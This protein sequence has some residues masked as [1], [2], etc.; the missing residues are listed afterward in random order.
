MNHRTQ[1]LKVLSAGVLSLILTMGVARFAYTPMLPI[2]QEQAGLGVS[3]GVWLAATNYLGYLAGALV[4]SMI[5]DLVLKD[6]LYRI[7]LL[8]AVLTT[9]GMGLTDNVWLWSLLRFLAG[10]STAAGMLLGSGLIMNWLIRHNHRAELGVTF[11]GVGLGMVLCAVA[12]ELMSTFLSWNDQWL[13]LTL[14]G[15]LIMILAWRWLPPP[16][17]ALL[18]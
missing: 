5:S 15:G 4:A 11:F 16:S 8:V 6:R 3:E 9:A 7:G 14:I 17:T 18:D 10:L 13:V 2:M 12:V 1:Q